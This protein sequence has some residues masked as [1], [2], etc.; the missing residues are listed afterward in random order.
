M[1]R[2]LIAATIVL[3]MPVSAECAGVR[4]KNINKHNYS[5]LGDLLSFNGFRTT[6]S[7]SSATG[8]KKGAYCLF[9]KNQRSMICGRTKI[10][11]LMPTVFEGATPWILTLD[12]FKTL[13]PILYPATVPRSR[14]NSITIDMGHGGNDPGALGAFSKEKMITLQIGRRTAEILRTYGF[15]VYCTRNSDMQIPLHNI[16]QIQKQHKSDLFVSIHVN[17]TKNKN[18]SGLETFCLTPAGAASSNGGNVSNT[19]HTGNRHDAANMLLAWS[20]HNSVL[21]RTGAADRGIKR[22]RFAVLRD[23]NVPGVLVE[24][25]F[26]SNRS[27][28]RKLND[29]KYVEKIARGIAEGIAAFTQSTKAR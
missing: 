6:I 26:I 29:P 12:W 27:E 15:K 2:F 16:A 4:Q 10:E 14:I 9:Q 20:I 24:T 1:L 21:Q 28:E 22:A 8:S 13:R 25:G 18:I 11:L 5:N 23:L 17:S 7:K 19:A 3:L